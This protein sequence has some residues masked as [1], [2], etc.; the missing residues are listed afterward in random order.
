MYAFIYIIEYIIIFFIVYVRGSNFFIT[1]NGIEID[2][3]LDDVAS[4]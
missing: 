1:K 3:I 2:I 4:W